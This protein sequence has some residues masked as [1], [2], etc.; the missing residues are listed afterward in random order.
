MRQQHILL[1]G[2]PGHDVPKATALGLRHSVVQIPQ[3]ASEEQRAS[4]ARYAVQDYRDLDALLPLVRDWHEAEP[5]DAVLSFTEY[6]LEP[7]SRVAIDLGIAGDNLEAV[8]ATRDKTRT[9]ALL[10]RH[11]LSPVRHR[12]C[13]T[14]ADAADFLDE[15]DGLPLVLKPP[16]GGL[17]EGVYLVEDRARLAER[18]AWTA[19]VSGREPVLA[20][21]YLSGPEFSVESISRHG[22]HEVVMVT[23]KLTTGFPGFV[24][25]GHQLPARLGSGDLEEIEKLILEFLALIGQRTGPVHSELRL[26]PRGPRLIEA[27]TRA[28]GDQIWEMCELVSGADQITETYCALLGR[29]DPPRVPRGRAAAIRFFSEENVRVRAVDGVAAAEAAPG[30]VRAVCTLRP[31]AELGPLLSSTSR[32]GYVLCLGEDT[33][34]AVARAETAR[35][36]VRVES[37]PLTDSVSPTHSTPPTGP[38]SPSGPMSPTGHEPLTGAEPGP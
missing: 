11:G 14:E 16:S 9:R 5:F 3:R 18:W 1:I 28:G 36:L 7:A 34:D 35:A 4:A 13:A 31:G 21:E 20:E 23:E 27:Q 19:A 37:E 12:V 8:L 6:G 33:Q 22:V 29:P 10:D 25:L 32:Q 38:V 30:V 17:S 15:L 24:E 26:T 2:G